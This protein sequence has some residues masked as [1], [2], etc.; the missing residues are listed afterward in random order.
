MVINAAK[1]SQSSES[2]KSVSISD[3]SILIEINYI[4]NQSSSSESNSKESIEDTTE[5]LLKKILERK[6]V[7]N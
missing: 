1:S 5:I 4:L 7:H 6:L 3:E 2:K